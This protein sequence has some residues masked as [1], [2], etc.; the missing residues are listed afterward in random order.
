MN[1]FADQKEVKRVV[2]E[3]KGLLLSPQQSYVREFLIRTGASKKAILRQYK[4]DGSDIF[5][6]H[7]RSVR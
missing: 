6:Q 4:F 7:N 2:Q 1:A 5:L 3:I